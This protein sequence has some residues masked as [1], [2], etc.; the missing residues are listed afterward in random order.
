MEDRVPLAQSTEDRVQTDLMDQTDRT[1]PMDQA[2]RTDQMDQAGR[3]D[4]MDQTEVRTGET[5]NVNNF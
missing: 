4:Q 3:T 1:V 2:G 5:F